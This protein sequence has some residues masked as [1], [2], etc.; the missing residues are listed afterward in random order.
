MTKDWCAWQASVTSWV[1]KQEEYG[2]PDWNIRDCE[3]GLSAHNVCAKLFGAQGAVGRV[4]GLVQDAWTLSLR[5]PPSLASTTA[6]GNDKEIAAALEAAQAYADSV[7]SKM[8]D[9]KEAFDDLN[10]AKMDTAAFETPPKQAHGPARPR[11]SPSS[12]APASAAGAA[13]TAARRR[14]DPP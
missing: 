5:S 11:A 13:A 4:A 8:R 1:G 10:S 14:P 7:F 3:A 6:L 9:Q 12:P 2:H